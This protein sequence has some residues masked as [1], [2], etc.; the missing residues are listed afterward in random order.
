[1]SILAR[2]FEKTD[3]KDGIDTLEPKDLGKHL[4]RLRLQK[5]IALRQL[6]SRAELS[7]AALSAIERGQSSPT[8]ATLHKV[9]A[10]LQTNFADFFTASPN[11]GND[12]IFTSGEMN[13][14]HDK[15]RKYTILFP[16]REDIKIEVVLETIA[17]QEKRSEWETHT[18][19]MGGFIIAGGPL[20]FEIE[21]EP[22]WKLKKGDAFYVK[23]NT[24]HRAINLG[25]TPIRQATVWHPPRY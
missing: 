23:A 24:K 3:R 4:R 20:L 5:G 13:T 18:C 2:L 11:P 19:D 16:K 21:G 6:S 1:L 7:A 12:M 9:L 22:A 25:K 10:A 14:L 15:Y 8:L 17:P